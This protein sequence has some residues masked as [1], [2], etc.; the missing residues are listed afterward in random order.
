MFEP[1]QLNNQTKLFFKEEENQE[2]AKNYSVQDVIR[3]FKTQKLNQLTLYF[4][5]VTFEK[6][7]HMSKQENM[8]HSDHLKV[9]KSSSVKRLS[10]NSYNNK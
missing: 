10:S 7:R 5:S 9:I 2:N 3:L 1:Y 6:K 8:L 4:K